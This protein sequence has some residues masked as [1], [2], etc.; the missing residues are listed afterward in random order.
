PT[1]DGRDTWLATM[2]HV[3]IEGRCF[4][5]SCNQFARRRD[6]PGDYRTAFGEE[7]ET[8][9][10]RGG[11]C[12]VGPLGEVLAGPDFAGETILTAEI[13][14]AE[15]ARSRLDFDVVGH[16]ARPDVFQLTVDETSRSPVAFRNAV[17][18]MELAGEGEL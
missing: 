4:V 14:L 13:D 7:P 10:S 3:A 12:I 5:L 1:A 18:P 11:S 6:Y 16:Y 17:G 2:R 9:I 15:I 8:V